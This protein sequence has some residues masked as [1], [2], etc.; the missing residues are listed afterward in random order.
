MLASGGY[1]GLIIFWD[2]NAGKAI[3]SI[4]LPPRVYAQSLSFSPNGE[5][6]AAGS[7]DGAI[8]FWDTATGELLQTVAGHT[9]IAASLAFTPDGKLLASASYDGTIRLWGVEP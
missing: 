9:N 7:D 8:Y 6:L 2:V 5:V 1:D 3:K 4:E